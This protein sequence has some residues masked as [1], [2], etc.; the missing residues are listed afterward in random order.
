MVTDNF[1]TSLEL[2]K[3]LNSWNMTLVGTVRR[4]KRFLPSNMQPSK[5]RVLNST[6]FA[7]NADAT[8]CSYVPKR[9]K[10]V[11]LLSTMHMTG[12][13]EATQAAKPEIIKYYNKT[14]G[15]VDV[16]DKM[17]GEYTVKRKT[18]RWP[19]AFFY[20]M[21]DVAA[22]ASYI[23]YREHNPQFKTKD[24]RRFFLKDLSNELCKPEVE[25][26]STCQKI[27]RNPF[28]RG[29]MEMVLG[30][31]IGIV[32]KA[33]VAGSRE[34]HLVVGSCYFCRDLKRKQRKTRK[35]CV[36]CGRP[37]CDEHSKAHTTCINCDED[38]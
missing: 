1:F 16:M 26:R 18:L 7:Y 27:V 36:V 5:E 29:A 8:L 22:L 10:A 13:I 35:S 34:V 25:N 24:Q 23:I 9:N 30:R 3:V 12:D 6:N 14:K 38:Q 2:A 17:V 21:V 15:G 20:N 31:Q 4:N 33:A 28:L 11:V 37:I 19:L 32:P